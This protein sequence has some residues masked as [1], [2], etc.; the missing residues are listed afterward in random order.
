[1]GDGYY[2][3]M[4]LAGAPVGG[5]LVAPGRNSTDDTLRLARTGNTY[6]AYYLVDDTTWTE[7]GSHTVERTPQSVGLIAA[8]APTAGAVAE[9]DYFEITEVP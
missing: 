1:M 7:L 8:Q 6:A 4:I 3:D 2:F 5:N 9:F